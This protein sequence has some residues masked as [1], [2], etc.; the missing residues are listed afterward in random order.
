[1]EDTLNETKIEIV[2]LS[3]NNIRDLQDLRRVSLPTLKMLFLFGNYIETPFEEV[4]EIISVSFENL[5]ELSL[6]GNPMIEML[7][8]LP[9]FNEDP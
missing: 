9:D 1:M 7:D 6:N 4:C 3:R 2:N 5:S 8:D